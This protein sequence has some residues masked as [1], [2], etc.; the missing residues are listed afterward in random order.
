MGKFKVG[1]RVRR[2]T[3]MHIDGM[4][5]G[6]AGIVCDTFGE[7][8]G[9][10]EFP[11]DNG[12]RT[13][14]HEDNFELAWQPKVGDRV[15]FTDK[16]KDYWWFGPHT[17][18][19]DGE[20]SLDRGSDYDF[21]DGRFE[22]RT[23]DSYGI[24]G[25]RHIEPLP[26][27]AEAQ[28]AALVVKAGKYYR[29]RD[30]RKVGPMFLSDDQETAY[31]FGGEIEGEPGA[32]WYTADG[33]W[34]CDGSEAERDII[35]E[36]VDEH[37]AKATVGAQVDTIAEE[38]GPV[39]AASNDNAKP[40][41]KVGDIVKRSG[42]Y[43][44]HQRMRVVEVVNPDSFTVEWLDGGPGSTHG[45]RA[46]ELELATVA[47]QQSASAAGFTIPLVDDEPANDN[48]LAVTLTLE[49]DDL[50]EELD[51]IIAKLKKIRKLQRRVGLAA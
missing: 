20:I 25:I 10:E 4:G 41:F 24:V 38:Y 3:G 22:V 36:W 21:A 6:D 33:N 46:Y 47:P 40:K 45:W 13:P 5:V 42:N 19:K 7:W 23:G 29:T 30:G 39:V 31:P 48:T 32:D 2:T 37:A 27:A 16:C 43:A 1:D 28:P 18:N 12:D 34:W 9:V 51:G 8:I 15:R 50:H 35:V 14:F 49:A 44:P 11:A 26:V 17:E